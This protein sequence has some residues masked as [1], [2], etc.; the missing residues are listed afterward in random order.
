[1][2]FNIAMLKLLSRPYST[3]EISRKENAQTVGS[4]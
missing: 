1:M 2:L 4:L 3:S